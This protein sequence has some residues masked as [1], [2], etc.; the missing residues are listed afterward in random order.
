MVCFSD[1]VDVASSKTVMTLPWWKLTPGPPLL[2]LLLFGSKFVQILLSWKEFRILEM[3]LN[4]ETVDRIIQILT[5]VT[6]N[7]VED[8]RRH[9]EKYRRF[10]DIGEK[11]ALDLI[12]LQQLPF[13]LME[14]EEIG[15][16]SG[17]LLLHGDEDDDEEPMNPTELIESITQDF[18]I[19][20][21]EIYNL[22]IDPTTSVLSI[23]KE[24]ESSFTYTGIDELYNL[25]YSIHSSNYSEF[26]GR[27]VSIKSAVKGLFEYIKFGLTGTDHEYIVAWVD[28]IPDAPMK[29]TD[30][31][32]E[33]FDRLI[34]NLKSSIPPKMDNSYL[35]AMA[36]IR[37]IGLEEGRMIEI[38]KGIRIRCIT[39]FEWNDLCN[40]LEDKRN[41]VDVDY[42]WVHYKRRLQQILD[43][44]D[45]HRNQIPEVFT[46]AIIE[47][48]ESDKAKDETSKLVR[49]AK[50]ME[51]SPSVVRI[52]EDVISC[53]RLVTGYSTGTSTVFTIP[54]Y[55]PDIT[56]VPPGEREVS[57][58]QSYRPAPLI[59]SGHTRLHFINEVQAAKLLSLWMQYRKLFDSS[60][61]DRLKDDIETSLNWF[62]R[63]I[64]P[65]S[66]NETM[67]Y[68]WTAIEMLFRGGREAVNVIRASILASE[69][70]NIKDVHD[71]F[72]TIKEFRNA[73]AHGGSGR[74]KKKVIDSDS[75]SSLV[76]TCIRN[77]IFVATDAMRCEIERLGKFID[78]CIINSKTRQ[79]LKDIIPDWSWV[80]K[81]S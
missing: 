59:I 51:Q 22:W 70:D 29:T 67:F 62:N 37:D 34:A 5:D 35:Y 2:V 32:A 13:L 69:E 60:D 43:E 76:R 47:A 10:F 16:M 77:A 1:K 8:I 50:I 54:G 31:P 44:V 9:C 79:V 49:F 4:Q 75:A 20:V 7:S 23:C 28:E 12:A 52:I 46:F 66:F 3:S 61:R 56:G 30:V 58:N 68:Y 81:S 39:P 48:W 78:E 19:V 53:I 24:F 25:I 26:L 6:G 41:D 65:Q 64:S 36:V 40:I 55:I 15:F 42:D 63:S 27:G 38:D 45:Y 18:K 33:A 71:G 73:Y 74:R 14:E 57:V 11:Q 80:E 17:E 72:D 21:D